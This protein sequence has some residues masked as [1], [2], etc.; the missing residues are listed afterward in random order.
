[1]KDFFY[2]PKKKKKNKEDDF[3][4]VRVDERCPWLAL[5]Y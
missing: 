3:I 5:Q 2:V 1:L 4:D